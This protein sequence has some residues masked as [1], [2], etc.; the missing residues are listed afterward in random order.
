MLAAAIT[1]TASLAVTLLGAPLGPTPAGEGEAT[2]T[3][4][5]QVKNDRPYLGGKP[6]DLWGLRC[7]NALMSDAVTERHVRCLDNMTAHGIN[8]VGCYVQG[9]NGGWPDV[10]AG[11]DGFT[12]EGALRPEFARRLEWLIREADRCGMVVMVGVISPRKD[13]ELKD[14]AAIQ[15]A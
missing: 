7:G 8:C 4:Q 13:Q 2:P 10:N 9:S 6:I 1:L 14:E 12:P 3:R 15:H 11:R 5:F